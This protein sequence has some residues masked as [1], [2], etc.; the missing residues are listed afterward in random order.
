MLLLNGIWAEAVVAQM[1]LVSFL[2]S[3]WMVL[4]GKNILIVTCHHFSTLPI[5]FQGQA[6]SYRFWVC[7]SALAW[8]NFKH[9][10]SVLV[11]VNLP[12]LLV[13]FLFRLL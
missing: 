7:F 6:Y 1:S 12:T 8:F 9:F 11:L 10:V 4:R 5:S 3:I 2:V 13:N